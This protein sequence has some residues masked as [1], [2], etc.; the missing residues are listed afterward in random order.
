MIGTGNRTNV[1]VRDS[2][3]I[4]DGQARGVNDSGVDGETTRK[5]AFLLPLCPVPARS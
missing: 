1:A 5:P 3:D 2:G 4:T